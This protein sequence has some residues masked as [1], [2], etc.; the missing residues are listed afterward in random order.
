MLIMLSLI[1]FIGFLISGYLILIKQW[2]ET[3]KNYKPLCDINKKISCSA[4]INSKYSALFGLNNACM[5]LIFYAAIMLLA[6]FNYITLI[7]ILAIAS[8]FVSFYLAY[9][10]YFKVKILCPACIMLYIVNLLLLITA[11]WN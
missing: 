6:L 2:M 9:I 3:H 1:S 10:L 4:V 7:K 5:G 8:G 11:F